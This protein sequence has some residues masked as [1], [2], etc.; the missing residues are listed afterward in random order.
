MMRNQ[1]PVSFKG[2]LLFMLVLLNGVV[3]KHA[4][5]GSREWLWIC[6]FTL[7]MFLMVI[8]KPLSGNEHT[9]GHSEDIVRRDIEEANE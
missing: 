2:S 1:K 4:Y 6:L 5:T 7:P 8:R 9:S 3:I